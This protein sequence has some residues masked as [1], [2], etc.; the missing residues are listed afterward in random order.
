MRCE[1]RNT[2]DG[3]GGS[4]YACSGCLRGCASSCRLPAREHA[5]DVRRS[6]VANHK[7][8]CDRTAKGNVP[9]PLPLQPIPRACGGYAGTRSLLVGE[10][11]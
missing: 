2:H 11:L 3:G 6:Q 8:A 1:L 7:C 4:S 5:G 10:V 9:G